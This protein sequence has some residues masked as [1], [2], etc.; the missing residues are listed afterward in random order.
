MSDDKFCVPCSVIG[1]A[2]GGTGL[3]HEVEL[4]PQLPPPPIG[5]QILDAD[6]RPE[7]AASGAR[8]RAMRLLTVTVKLRP[9]LTALS[10][11]A[12]ASR[13]TLRLRAESLGC[14]PFPEWTATSG[15]Q[16]VVRADRHTGL[17]RSQG[18][19]A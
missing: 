18:W 14:P 10:P 6:R 5:G 17:G 16:Q 1:A 4:P 13:G 15:S 19:S 12:S 3:Q 11:C 8:R 7:I 2:L 9:I